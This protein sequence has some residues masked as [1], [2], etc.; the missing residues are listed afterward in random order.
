MLRVSVAS[1]R[2]VIIDEFIHQTAQAYI[3]LSHEILDI[4]KKVSILGRAYVKMHM[5]I[6]VAYGSI[7][8]I[9]FH[10]ETPP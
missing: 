5:G 3:V 4:C 10:S 7:E 8:G 9:F 1:V 2:E 6:L